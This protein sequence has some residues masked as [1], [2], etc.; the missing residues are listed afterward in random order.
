LDNITKKKIEYEINEINTNLS[1]GKPLIDLCKLKELDFIEK[2]AAGSILHSFYNGLENLTIIIL[3]S[4]EEKLPNDQ[5]WHQT[6]LDMAFKATKN[7]PAIF[8]MEYK[9][10]LEEYKDFRHVFR[11]TYGFKINNEQ[12]K[13]LING[14]EKLWENIKN[15]ITNFIN[16]PYARA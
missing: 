14:V 12:L 8:N 2:N 4:N 6:L 13:P 5:H 1:A 7:R 16:S 10:K 9:E 11:H 15:D 3:K